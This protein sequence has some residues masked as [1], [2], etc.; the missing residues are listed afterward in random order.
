MTVVAVMSVLVAGVVVINRDNT[1]GT[2]FSALPGATGQPA[3]TGPTGGGSGGGLGGPPFPLQPPDMPSGPPNGYNGGGY[4]APDQGNGIS[5]Y[6]SDA[7]QSPGGRGG[8]QQAP[9]YPQQQLQPANGV[10][11][12]DYDAPLQ[13]PQ[14]QTVP[15]HPAQNRLNDQQPQQ[16]S[17]QQQPTTVTVTV[18]ASSEPATSPPLSASPTASTPPSN[19]GSQNNGQQRSDVHHE[20]DNDNSDKCPGNVAPLYANDNVSETETKPMTVKD[21]SPFI[22]G[23]GQV[24]NQF[25]QKELTFQIAPGTPDTFAKAFR[26]AAKRWNGAQHKIDVHEVGPTAW[27][28]FVGPSLTFNVLDSAPPQLGNGSTSPAQQA[29]NTITA[30]SHGFTNLD[31]AGGVEQLIGVMGHEIG[32]ALGLDHSCKG[33]IMYYQMGIWMATSPTPLDIAILNSITR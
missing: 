18:T 2:G 7:P 9:S 14:P 17:Q 20:G 6:N 19:N 13:T 32:H 16:D 3:P 4:P 11:P 1:A 24:N 5:I 8:Y 31:T 33:A 27:Y 28:D 22:V 21:P 30:W 12:P 25:G 10:Q 15:Q 29:G 23:P 26:E